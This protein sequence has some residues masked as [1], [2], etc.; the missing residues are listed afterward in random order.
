MVVFTVYYSFQRIKP[1]LKQT[2]LIIHFNN[3]PVKNYCFL[4]VCFG[5]QM[6]FIVESK[7]HKNEHMSIRQK[8]KSQCSDIRKYLC[9]Y[10]NAI[11]ECSDGRS[12]NY[13]FALMTLVIIIFFLSYCFGRSVQFK[14][15][16]QSN[17]FVGSSNFSAL[18]FFNVYN[19]LFAKMLT[20][21]PIM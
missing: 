5:F 15:P 10:F 14:S 13:W 8:V 9:S 2:H 7:C 6:I 18:V 20:F 16:N 12:T 11:N 3:N 19:D 21:T 1:L 4:H 17:K